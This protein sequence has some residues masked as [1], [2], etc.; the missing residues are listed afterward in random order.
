MIFSKKQALEILSSVKSVVSSKVYEVHG[1]VLNETHTREKEDLHKI[2]DKLIFLGKGVILDSLLS[3][4]E[5][6]LKVQTPS[7]RAYAS[8]D[9]ISDVPY[10]KITVASTP[11][12]G[13]ELKETLKTR[14]DKDFRSAFVE[15]MDRVVYKFVE[16][17]IAT[18][19]VTA[20]NNELEMIQQELASEDLT[21]SFNLSFALH[22]KPI[23]YISDEELVLGT[24][25][26]KMIQL[27]SPNSALVTLFEKAEET[28]YIAVA[29]KEVIKEDWFSS[30]NPSVFIRKHNKYLTPLVTGDLN[31]RRTQ[32][33]DV[34]IKNSF[35]LVVESLQ[36]RKKSIAHKIETD[37]E[38]TYISVFEKEGKDSEPKQLLSPI[39]V[40]SLTFQS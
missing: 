5:L 29:L 11:K 32:R 38:E 1:A 34:L 40:K 27:V 30:A 17:A 20:L 12:F 19:N 16:T 37:G 39:N 21:V 25:T 9:A 6:G 18:V 24:T 33:V 8:V 23:K 28:D 10:I 13:F 2:A 4:G 26:D 36:Y 35:P 14:T 15:F 7:V 22:E 3:V 31:T